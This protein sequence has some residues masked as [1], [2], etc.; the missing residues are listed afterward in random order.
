M[1]VVEVVQ[2]HTTCPSG[3]S[4]TFKIMR[5]CWHIRIARN[6]NRIKKT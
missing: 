3:S 5:A 1:R 2:A 6:H 4:I